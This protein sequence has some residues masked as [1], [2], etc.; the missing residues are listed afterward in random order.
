MAGTYSVLINTVGSTDRC[1]IDIKNNFDNQLKDDSSHTAIAA[2][3]DEFISGIRNIN[4]AMSSISYKNDFDY[5]DKRVK[6]QLKSYPLFKDL[7]GVELLFA[8][9]DYLINQINSKEYTDSIALM[10]K[11]NDLIGK[12]QANIVSSFKRNSYEDQVRIE[13][14]MEKLTGLSHVDNEHEL[15]M[16]IAEKTASL[17]N[18]TQA[19]GLINFGKDAINTSAQFTKIIAKLKNLEIKLQ[20][21]IDDYKRHLAKI[22]ENHELSK[23]LSGMIENFRRQHP[24]LFKN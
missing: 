10:V 17:Y 1:L 15:Q 13:R 18:L 20:S 12:R 4:R 8:A 3:H 14:A 24:E 11:Y 23:K 2:M 19:N 22:D 6:D 7:Q 5:N 9:H 21:R 16:Y